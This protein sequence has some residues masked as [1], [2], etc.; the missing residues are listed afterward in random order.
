MFN[1]IKEDLKRLSSDS[2]N[3]DFRVIVRGLL[4]QGFQAILVYR[5][6]NFLRKN[7]IPAQPFRFIF[8]RFIEITTG[9]S[10]P[11]ECIIGK[12]LRIHHFGGVIFHPS[13]VMG[14]YCTL[15]H[16][17][18]IGDAGGYGLA[19]QIG[20]HVMIGAGAKIIGEI[21]IGD[22]CRI[23]ANAVV[24]INVSDYSVCYGNPCIIKKREIE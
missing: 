20:N 12:G 6:F 8:E 2:Q 17:V 4:S 9:I 23:G 13:V 5:F 15:Y 18:T 24:N 21:H 7:H 11:A 3:L 14:E 19:A 16:G 10:I 1:N 22:Y